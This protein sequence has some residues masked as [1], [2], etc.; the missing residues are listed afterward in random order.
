MPKKSELT[1]ADRE[2]ILGVLEQVEAVFEKYLRPLKFLQLPFGI[3]LFNM[4]TLIIKEIPRSGRPKA[5]NN[6]DKKVL[7]DIIHK[8][9]KYSA[10]KIQRKMDGQLNTKIKVKIIILSK[11]YTKSKIAPVIKLGSCSFGIQS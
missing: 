10:D 4:R 8:G 3:P 1:E 7:K 11:T 9:N 6:D 2:K 5:I